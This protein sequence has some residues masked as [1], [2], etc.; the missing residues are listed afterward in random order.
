MSSLGIAP[1]R[2]PGL[3]SEEGD[4]GELVRD[5][6]VERDFCGEGES[7][8]GSLRLRM[9]RLRRGDMVV[10]GVGMVMEGLEGGEVMRDVLFPCV[11][12]WSV[13]EREAERAFTRQR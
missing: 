13:K 6:G 11:V 2:P 8:G 10:R 1:R 7:V 3:G 12:L 9:P 4:A 5:G